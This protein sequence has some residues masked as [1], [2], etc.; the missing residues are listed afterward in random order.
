MSQVQLA[1]KDPAQI[2]RVAS[3]LKALSLAAGLERLHDLKWRALG[4]D[5]HVDEAELP[6]IIIRGLSEEEVAEIFG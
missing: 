3:G 1:Q 2:L 4:L 5:K 6:Q